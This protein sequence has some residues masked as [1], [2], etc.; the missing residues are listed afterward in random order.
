MVSENDEEYLEQLFT[1]LLRVPR[2]RVYMAEEPF[3]TKLEKMIRNPSIASALIKM[4]ER[5]AEA[6]EVILSVDDDTK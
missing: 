4:D 3:L 5:L 6:Q 2:I 1:K